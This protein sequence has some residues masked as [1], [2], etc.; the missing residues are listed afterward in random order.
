[1]IAKV[2]FPIP[3]R[4]GAEMLVPLA[5]T[6]LRRELF[7]LLHQGIGPARGIFH[8]GSFHSRNHRTA[9]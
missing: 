3:A 1:M 7:G 8:T 5:P 9:R 2:I 4:C 6:L